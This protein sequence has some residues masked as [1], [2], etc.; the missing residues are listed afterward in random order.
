ML[1]KFS[2]RTTGRSQMINITGR[3]REAIR[4]WG[5]KDGL[6]AVYCPHTTA[7]ITINEGADPDVAR[8]FLLRLDELCP[9]E[10]PLYRHREGNSAAHLKAG[11]VG[12]SQ[13]IPVV[14]S[15]L[16]IGIWQA[17][18]FCEFD[19]PQERFYL[20]KMIAG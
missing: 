19:G 16:A 7:G 10:H 3:V 12:A 18:Y 15:D 5:N 2:L 14:N 6:V 8:D 9:W 20:V 13:V 17:V 11:M 4:Q 1:Q